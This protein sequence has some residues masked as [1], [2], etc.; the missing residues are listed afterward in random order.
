MKVTRSAPTVDQAFRH[1][2]GVYSSRADLV[3]QL[4][5]VAA[6]ARGRG[7]PVALALHP[8]TTDDLVEHLGSATG[9][10]ALATPYGPD[11]GSG[12][13]VAVARAR[14]LRELTDAVGP[15]TVLAEHLG[16]LD[17]PDGG[18]WTELDAATNIALGPLPIAMTC[19][20]P[21]LPLH[22]EV[23][24]GAR[25]N[26]PQ[27]L[28][29]GAARTNGAHRTPREVLSGHRVPAPVL[30]GAPERRITFRA[31]ELQQVRQA[32]RTTAL[33]AGFERSRA[34]DVVLAVNEVATN[35][36]EHG[37]PGSGSDKKE[38]QLCLWAGSGGLVCEVHDGGVLADPLPGLQPPH[39]SDPRG[40]GLWIARQICDLLHVWT[41]TSGTHVRLRASP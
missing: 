36:V 15:V 29:D 9:L 38:A 8:A 40:R 31:F 6:A 26:H 30:L 41:D 16:Q 19:F 21:E 11:A 33:D 17:G 7:E 20:F 23:L 28:V 13:T 22:Q 27:L 34:E 32:V 25:R 3:V 35:A 2:L 4:V 12:Q 37:G 14:E 18:Y 5:E 24:D 1:S 10:Q 39:P